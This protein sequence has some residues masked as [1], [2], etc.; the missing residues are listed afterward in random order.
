MYVLQLI[1]NYAATYSLLI[2]GLCECVAIAYIYGK[3][4]NIRIG[5]CSHFSKKSSF[6]IRTA[7]LIILALFQVLIDFSRTLNICWD[8]NL[9]SGGKSCGL[10]LPLSF[11][12]WVYPT[13]FF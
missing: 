9:N 6:D 3:Y 5:R 12:L 10:L 13:N 7:Q 4:L 1:D 11:L 8:V 2:I